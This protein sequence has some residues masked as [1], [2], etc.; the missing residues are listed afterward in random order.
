M[1]DFD[2]ADQAS[3]KPANDRTTSFRGVADTA[4]VGTGPSTWPEFP[5]HE[6]LGQLGAGGMGVV[7]K[8]R[9]VTRDSIVA[10]KTLLHCGAAD[11]YRFKQE[12]RALADLNHPN[13]VML[14]QL[15]SA[16]EQW[17]FTME[18][19]EGQDFLSALRPA[20]SLDAPTGAYDPLA[21]PAMSLPTSGEPAPM[22]G[23]DEDRLRDELRQLGEGLNFLHA[24]GK[25]H[26]DLKP[27][28]V[29]VERGGRVVILDFGLVQSTAEP[30][31]TQAASP[32]F[33]DAPDPTADVQMS[34]TRGDAIRG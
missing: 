7:Y 16:R 14:Y 23:C 10:L 17:C 26:C 28:N 4:P 5:G 8:A 20:T 15:L 32:T 19:V 25:L 13:L 1:P 3:A 12:F 27:S 21:V 31:P 18:L 11:L 2:S 34:W 24:G 22:Q 33:A 29:M 30:P 9:D 6:I